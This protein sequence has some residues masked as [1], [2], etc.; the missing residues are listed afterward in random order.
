VIM[1]DP[2]KPILRLYQVPP[3]TFDDPEWSG[4]CLSVKGNT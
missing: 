4:M 3:E 2:N 1:R